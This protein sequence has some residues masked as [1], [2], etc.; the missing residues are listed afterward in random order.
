MQTSAVASKMLSAAQALQ[1]RAL[2]EELQAAEGTV[3][4]LKRLIAEIENG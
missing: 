4:E 3:R 1:V 2:K